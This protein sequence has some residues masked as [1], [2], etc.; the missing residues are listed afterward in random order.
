MKRIE[1]F[2]LA[3]NNS[4]LVDSLLSD[5]QKSGILDLS[6]EVIVVDNGSQD[7]TAD[8]V[9]LHIFAKYLRLNENRYFSGGANFFLELA[10]AEHV[11]F[12][13]SDVIPNK[14]TISSIIALAES[15][16]RLG[17][18][19][20]KSRLLSGQLQDIVKLVP[21]RM[22]MHALHGC[23]GGLPYLKNW[24]LKRYSKEG[25]LSAT[26]CYV[27]VVQDSFI[28]IRGLLIQN[29]LRYDEGMRLYYT[30]DFICER[31]KTL[32]YEIGFC[33]N[34]EVIH[35]SGATADQKKPEIR[36]IYHDDAVVF[37]RN[38]YG[39]FS[40]SLL[41]IDIAIMLVLS[42]VKRRINTFSV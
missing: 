23:I 29:G 26:N 37:S 8:I 36:K 2:I 6:I 40:A 9:G 16:P 4:K 28:Y 38:K 35:I 21:S 33:S 25:I 31:V 13:N 18:I 42:A 41:K 14:N 3:Y 17:I 22:H 32:G 19:G 34:A 15:D 12:M 39:V 20:C 5:I 1:L 24:I 10:R 11:F 7:N 30:E 27:E